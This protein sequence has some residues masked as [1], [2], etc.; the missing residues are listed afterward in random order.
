M[1]LIIGLTGG[2]GSGKSTVA[3][4]FKALD[5][6]VIDADNISRLV[7]QK[8]QPALAKIVTYFGSDI[9]IDGE[10]NRTKL[11]QCI[12]V[13]ETKKNWLNDLLHPL[14]RSEMLAQLGR[15]KGKYV[16]LEA[17]L[18]FENKLD[19]YCEHVVVI[20]IDEQSQVNR[21]SIRDNCTIEQIKAIISSQISR[22]DRLAKAS[23]V[24]DNSILTLAQLEMSVIALDIQLRALQ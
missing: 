18:L 3:G 21:A 12:F 19:N 14:I 22:Q 6:E 11:R 16:L 2:I 7:V 20:D 10:L 1:S 9:L 8:G 13:D 24:I 17:P 5:I 4:F 15:A 23:F